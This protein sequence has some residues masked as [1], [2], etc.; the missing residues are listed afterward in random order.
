MTDSGGAQF[1]EK[2]QTPRGVDHVGVTVPDIQAASDFL[3]GAFSAVA[4]YDVQ[5]PDDDP[6]A[7]WGRRSGMTIVFSKPSGVTNQGIG[8]RQATAVGTESTP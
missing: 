2:V 5:S 8:A 4:V 1:M 7:P 3:A 6:M